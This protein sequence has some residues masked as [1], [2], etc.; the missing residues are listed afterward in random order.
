MAVLA[1]APAAVEGNYHVS[2][3]V[4]PQLG[5]WNM[6]NAPVVWQVAMTAHHLKN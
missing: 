4:V 5:H 1:V 6:P 3:V 2:D